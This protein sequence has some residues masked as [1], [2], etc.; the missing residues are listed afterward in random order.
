MSGSARILIID[1]EASILDT[2]E[3]LFRGEGYEVV[4][5]S[6]GARG[7]EAL[8]EEKPDL[9]LTDIRMPGV[10]GLEV[11][12]EAREVDPE[13]PVILMTAQASLP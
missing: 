9:V 13:L 10:T 1:D 12:A 11:L 7:K 4:R 8:R 6:S 5:A 3:I 2:L